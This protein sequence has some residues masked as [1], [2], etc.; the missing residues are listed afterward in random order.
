MKHVL[1][2]GGTGML[3]KTTSWLAEQADHTVVF[4]R[5]KSRAGRISKKSE[6]NRARL[7]GNRSIKSANNK[8][9]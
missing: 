2:F 9:N 7:H 6:R 3:A 5:N 4:A 8:G 1:V